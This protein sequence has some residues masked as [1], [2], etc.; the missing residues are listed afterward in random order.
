MTA[1]NQVLQ[2]VIWD[3]AGHE[4]YSSLV[5]MHIRDVDIAVIVASFDS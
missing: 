5:P 4:R 3:T 1:M 2:L